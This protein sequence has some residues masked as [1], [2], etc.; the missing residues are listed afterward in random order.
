MIKIIGTNHEEFRRKDFDIENRHRLE[1]FDKIFTE[2]FSQEGFQELIEFTLLG[3]PAD[4]EL[5]A[6]VRE[7]MQRGPEPVK[8][9][10]VDEE[11]IYLD[12]EVSEEVLEG[13]ER[14]SSEEPGDGDAYPLEFLGEIIADGQESREDYIDFMRK[15]R[16]MDFEEDG[17]YSSYAALSREG[18]DALMRDF[19][20]IMEHDVD[21]RKIDEDMDIEEAFHRGLERYDITLEDY[22]GVQA[23]AR[24]D[25]RIRE[26]R[27]G[28][29]R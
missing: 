1:H 18:F 22:V 25:F 11:V 19:G 6:D 4:P 10:T 17:G 16:D 21:P 26:I 5:H 7:T 3:L 2:G 29:N 28:T 14:G 24:E 23:E 15:I 20:A 27:N 8:F 13:M 9:D 12:D